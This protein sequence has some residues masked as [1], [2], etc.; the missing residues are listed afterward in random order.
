[1]DVGI[2]GPIK[3]YLSNIWTKWV[4]DAYKNNNED[5]PFTLTKPIREGVS[6]W[7]QEAWNNITLSTVV[8]FLESMLSNCFRRNPFD[9]VSFAVPPAEPTSFD[10]VEG[11]NSEEEDNKDAEADPFDNLDQDNEEL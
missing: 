5:K 9:E 4:V 10:V 6:I 8:N 11:N 3:K 1:M 2:N 7:L